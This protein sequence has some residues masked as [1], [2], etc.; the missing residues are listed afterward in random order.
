MYF[1]FLPFSRGKKR[2][3]EI[4]GILYM[5]YPLSKVKSIHGSK[6][7]D[8]RSFNFLH[9]SERVAHSALPKTNI[10][11]LAISK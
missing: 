6:L 2:E 10:C 5:G 1:M 7:F 9:S 11:R 8:I 4:F 3:R